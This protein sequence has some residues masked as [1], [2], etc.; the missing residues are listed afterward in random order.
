L[1]FYSFHRIY[2]GRLKDDDEGDPHMLYSILCYDCESEVFGMTKE[3]DGELMTRLSAVTAK[4]A[5]AGKLGPRLRLMATNAATTVRSS[6]EVIDGPFAET[7]EQLLGFYIVDC[8][9][10]E[11]A[12]ETARLLAREKS[13]GTYEVRPVLWYDS[14]TSPQTNE[15]K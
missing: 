10:Q 11:E 15:V 1:P 6:G 8:E 2:S 3:Q 13:N 5:A 14:G 12:V 7:K 9:S 4:Q